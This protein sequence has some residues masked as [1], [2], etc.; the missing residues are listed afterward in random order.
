MA[1]V[2]C[3]STLAFCATLALC[4]TLALTGG[5]ALAGSDLI[6]EIPRATNVES[7]VA[8][9]PGV[10]AMQTSLR[11]AL[12]LT[13][14]NARGNIVLQTVVFAVARPGVVVAPMSALERKGAGWTRLSVSSDT[15]LAGTGCVDGSVE[16]TGIR[17]IAPSTN[18]VGLE[19]PGLDPC[20]VYPVDPIYEDEINPDDPAGA[21]GTPRSAGEILTGVRN[22]AGYYGRTFEASVERSIVMPDGVRL[23][24]VGVGD[25]GRADNGF[26]LDDRGRIVAAVL[27]SPSGA[28]PLLAGA[29]EITSPPPDDDAGGPIDGGAADWGAALETPAGLFARALLLTRDDQADRVISLLDR[30]MERTG[31]FDDLL[32]ERG[33][34]RYRIGRAPAAI[35]DFRGA[36]RLSPTHHIALLNLGI[37]L[38]G[39]GLYMQAAQAFERALQIVPEDAPTHFNLA[40]A[41]LAARQHA[42]AIKE[43]EALGRLD[44]DLADELRPLLGL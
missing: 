23:L 4:T 36:A 31:E 33:L 35:E 37:A 42:L 21:T 28:N 5:P 7:P 30:V 11:C 13:G 17:W 34:R 1:M 10:P 25:G 19:A 39:E 26:L 15:P 40:M 41:R 9:A 14:E 24:L 12:Q 2:A 3:C 16:V 44:P 22:R 18:L 38:G 27:P 29:I 8:A 32:L 6:E 20:P 43:Y